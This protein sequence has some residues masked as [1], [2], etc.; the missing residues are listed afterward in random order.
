MQNRTHFVCPGTAEGNRLIELPLPG[1][2]LVQ[3]ESFGIIESRKVAQDIS[4]PVSGKVLE[5]NSRLETEPD[6]I[7]RDPFGEGWIML[8]E[9][10]DVSQLDS[11][12]DASRYQAFVE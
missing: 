9:V 3:S 11:L 5:V 7:N 6:L 8:V 1:T 2:E 12:M 4:S 10:G